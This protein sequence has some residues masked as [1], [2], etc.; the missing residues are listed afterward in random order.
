MLEADDQGQPQRRCL[1]HQQLLGILCKVCVQLGARPLIVNAVLVHHVAKVVIASALNA[2][3]AFNVIHVTAHLRLRMNEFLS[4]P[5]YFG[6]EV[7]EID[8]EEWKTR[9]EQFVSAGSVEKDVEQSALMRLLKP[10]IEMS[11]ITPQH[12]PIRRW[13]LLVL[14]TQR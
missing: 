10:S 4:A 13:N 8:Y 12:Q 11:P 1:R 6:F 3:H 5:S 7:P 9:L 14:F 2:L